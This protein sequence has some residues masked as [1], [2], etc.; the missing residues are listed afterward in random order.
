M[1]MQAIETI[2]QRM[3][4]KQN[5]P[6]L[7]WNGKEYSYSEFL[8]TVDEWAPKLKENG[9]TSGSV[10]GLVGDFSLGTCSLIFAL[11]KA[12]AIIVPFSYSVKSELEGLMEIAEVQFLFRF[13]ATDSWE[14]ETRKVTPGNELTVSFLKREVPGLIVFSSGSTGKPKGILHDCCRVV[15]KFLDQRKPQRTLL[16]LMIDHFGGF[17]T[18]L[19][20]F[21]YGGVGV[22]VGERAPEQVC[23]VIEQARVDLLPTTPTF[24]NLLLASGSYRQHNLSSVKLITYGT[25]VMPEATL[26]KLKEVFPHAKTKQTYG[27]SEL[28]VLRSKSENDSSLW[29]KV[30]GDGFEVKVVDQILWVRAR[31]NMVGYLNEKSPFDAEGWMCTGDFVETK[32]EYLRIIG[33]KSD[34][35]NVGGQKVFPAEVESVLLEAENISEA[36]VSGEKHPIMGHIVVARVSL[37]Q[38]EDPTKMKERLRMFCMS[39]LAKFKIPMKFIVVEGQ[40]HTDRFKK[41]RSAA[42]HEDT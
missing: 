34:L 31:S 3:T 25:E 38:P 1:S 30:G 16:F 42:I 23:K 14:V 2:F 5:A 8:R 26:Q 11:M 19:S 4:E 35:I 18:F 36:T 12:R 39:R 33:R 20:A 17:N 24:I 9:I 15:E 27:L 32:G 37:L 41:D 28:G 40:Q 6:A 29:V 10:C 21:A 22:C 13:D 7:F